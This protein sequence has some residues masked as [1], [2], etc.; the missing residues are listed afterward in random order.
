MCITIDFPPALE[1]EAREYATVKGK[2]LE[3]IVIDCLKAEF[4]RNRKQNATA[5]GLMDKW[6]EVVRKGRGRRVEPYV[7]NRAD[8]Y[9]DG[10]FA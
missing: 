4:E 2:T 1:Q 10:E 6:R 9:P 3:R 8:A 5:A 7:F